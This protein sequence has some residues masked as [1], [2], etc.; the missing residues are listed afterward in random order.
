MENKA[1]PLQRRKFLQYL[2][3]FQQGFQTFDSILQRLRSQIEHQAIIKR[4]SFDMLPTLIPLPFFLLSAFLIN[5]VDFKG[6]FHIDG[7]VISI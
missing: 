1:P 4:P 5:A 3:D 7:T 2:A 6:Y